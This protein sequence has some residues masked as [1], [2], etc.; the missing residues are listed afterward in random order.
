MRPL[1]R[2]H[3]I[4]LCF[5]LAAGGG[6]Q[7]CSSGGD[8]GVTP[9]P[10]MTYDSL[11]VTDLAAVAGSDTSVTL[12]W[13][14]PSVV[15]ATANWSIRYDLRHTSPG[16]EDAAWENWTAVATPTEDNQCCVAKQHTVGGLAAGTVHVFQ[17][18]CSTDG[19]AW[20][21]LSNLVVAT[22]GMNT[23]TTRPAPITDLALARD[24]TFAVTVVW[25]VAGD[26]SAYGE[27]SSYELRY[28]TDPLTEQNWASATIA[29][30][31]VLTGSEPGQRE[32]RFNT[33]SSDVDYYAAIR[34]HDDAGNESALSNLLTVRSGTFNTIY[35]NVEGTGD[36]PTIQAAID[37]AVEGDLIVVG[38]GRYT[39][40]N[41][42]G[43]DPIYSFVDVPITATGF[44][45]VIAETRFLLLSAAS[46]TLESV[47]RVGDDL[48]FT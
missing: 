26:D 19:E 2:Y 43:G 11:P 17:L 8:D 13:T 42:G 3:V 30:G 10:E 37:N 15:A 46:L 27:A 45:N 25:S 38:P 32:A 41:Q 5:L 20:S 14:V 7:G 28:A 40:T 48:D 24:D 47:T 35:V 23:D 1:R 18:R 22:A 9:E 21:E 6:L 16:G 39:W 29:D 33:L 12:G 31:R 4:F 34:S 36:Q 44:D